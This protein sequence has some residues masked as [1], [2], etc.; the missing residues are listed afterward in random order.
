MNGVTLAALC[1][2]AGVIL[3]AV[4]GIIIARVNAKKDTAVS[5]FAQAFDMSKYIDE[6]VEK[7]VAAEVER[8][9]KPL[10]DE[11]GKVKRVLGSLYDKYHLV[12]STFRE[13]YFA[14][15]P[16]M[17]ADTPHVD[18]QILRMISE[19]DED[20]KTGGMMEDLRA[21]IRTEDQAADI[22]DSVDIT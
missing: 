6:Q 10:R 18:P 1:T 9:T 17:G 13:F 5:S 21:S 22:D 16:K 14:V 15:R 2:L 19:D 7:K 8:Q 11:L 4:G 3:T 12:R 20:T